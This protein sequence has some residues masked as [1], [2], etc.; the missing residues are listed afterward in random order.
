LP[1]ELEGFHETLPSCGF[2][3]EH[4]VSLMWTVKT[5]E[6]LGVRTVLMSDLDGN[7]GET[8]GRR[9]MGEMT[10]I[11]RLLRSP[12]VHPPGRPLLRLER[13]DRLR[14]HVSRLRARE[15]VRLTVTHTMRTLA[16]RRTRCSRKLF[17][18]RSP[19]WGTCCR[20]TGAPKFHA[21]YANDRAVID[22]ESESMTPEL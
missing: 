5:Y 21:F 2:A 20:T 17:T 15:H 4:I 22:A 6:H 8:G 14:S 16:L 12:R 7:N 19:R 3:T 10:G 18:A 11:R 13:G 9:M 1:P